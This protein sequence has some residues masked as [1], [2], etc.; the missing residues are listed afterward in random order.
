M[1]RQTAQPGF[2]LFKRV[3][4]TIR[5]ITPTAQ[6]QN[7]IFTVVFHR[8][9][10][11]KRGSISIQPLFYAPALLNLPGQFFNSTDKPVYTFFAII[12]AQQLLFG[13]IQKQGRIFFWF[14]FRDELILPVLEQDKI[15]LLE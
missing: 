13:R 1:I 3:L 11:L 12:I 2:R 5:R 8:I 14:E 10:D 7:D 9:L 4:V 15:F 6:L